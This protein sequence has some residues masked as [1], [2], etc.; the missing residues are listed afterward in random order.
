MGNID[1]EV[2]H[3]QSVSDD[4]ALS[5][6]QEQIDFKMVTFSLGGKDYGID[7]MRVK[8]IAKFAQFTYVPNTAPFVRGV[9]NLRGDIISVI[10]LRLMFNLPAQEQEKGKPENGLILR[11]ETNMIGVVVD[12]ID[13]VVGISSSQVQPPHPIFGDIN[14][15]YISGVAEHEDRLYIILDVD[16]IF[17]RDS[18]E[19][20][21]AAQRSY[22]AVE[23][24]ATKAPVA[25][26]PAQVP[27]E[28]SPREEADDHGA[29]REFVIQG[30]ET[31]SGF[32]VTDLNR[33]WFDAR[34]DEWRRTRKAEG[35]DVQFVGEPDAQDFLS[36][37]HSRYTDRFW[38]NDYVT[39]I[40]HV[41]PEPQSQ[42]VHVW[43]PGCGAGYESFSIAA[44][45][46]VNFPN[47][48]V[49]VWAGDKDLMKISSAP[50][51]TF[52]RSDIPSE[53]TDLVV[54]GKN[55]LRFSEGTKELILFEFSDVLNTAGIPKMDYV[56]AR[57]LLSM[58]SESDQRSILETFE[59][60]LKP[61][62]ALLLGDNERV[63]DGAAWE[64]ITGDTLTV[65]RRR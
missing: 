30:L 4:E 32:Y 27:E 55:G 19:N 15:K 47:R 35:K 61:G 1:T 24:P 31:F 22:E 51:I 23:Q 28:K 14:V 33:E 3:D 65:Y 57:D 54:Q 56:V 62:G 6:R 20:E 45:L 18:E 16:R 60:T 48:Q 49:K 13:K 41:L 43:N 25:P 38:Q 12:H 63:T 59:E 46:R 50:N 52:N 2:L 58:H 64:E 10:D 53:W 29:E 44:L 37:F 9:Y 17:T 39:E 34:F 5:R 26:R 36:T 21:A 8:E 40:V 42:L 11:L 7:I